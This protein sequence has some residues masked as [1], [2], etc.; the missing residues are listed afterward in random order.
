MHIKIG[1][2]LPC[3][4]LANTIIPRKKRGLGFKYVIKKN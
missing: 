4:S 3:R 2:L 1:R